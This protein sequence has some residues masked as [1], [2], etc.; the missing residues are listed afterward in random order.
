LAKR[1]DAETSTVP[2]ASERPV[3][4]SISLTASST[5]ERQYSS[6]LI[7]LTRCCGV[8]A[9][10]PVSVT[11]CCPSPSWFRRSSAGSRSR[12]KVW[13]AKPSPNSSGRIVTVRDAFRAYASADRTAQAAR[14]YQN[15]SHAVSA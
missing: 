10:R 9:K 5:I 4:V 11:I 8:V 12:W 2:L 14:A 6:P 7:S 13:L 3:S 15:G 1:N